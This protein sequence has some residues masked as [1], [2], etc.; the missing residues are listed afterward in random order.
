[1]KQPISILCPVLN[2]Q[3]SLASL[4]SELL[5][6]LETNALEGEIIFIDDGSHDGTWDTIE[7]LAAAHPEIRGIRLQR[8][9][10]KSSALAAGTVASRF[11]IIVTIDGDLQDDPAEIPGMVA[12]LDKGFDLVSGWKQRRQDPWHRLLASRIFNGAVSKLTGVRLHDHNCGLKAARRE[13]YD[14]LALSGGLHRFIPVLAA[15]NGFRITERTVSHRSRKHG[16]S[17]YGLERVPRGFWDLLTVCFLT[18]HRERMQFMLGLTGAG[19]FLAGAGGLAWMAGYWILRM[20]GAVEG[21]PVHERPLVWYS[22]GAMLAGLQ[23]L[24]MGFLAEL[25]VQR[26]QSKSDGYL[27]S[28]ETK[29]N[30]QATNKSDGGRH[31]RIG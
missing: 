8:N 17:R 27:I 15:S 31:S 21:P 25:I 30:E 2:E 18:V 6:M 24:V 28:R 11:P 14:S 19:S 4:T 13:V 10:G 5:G 23:I 29:L 26:T 3:A 9:F 16:R 12:E 22:L 20:V 1:M 7:A